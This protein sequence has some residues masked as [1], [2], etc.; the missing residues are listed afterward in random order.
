MHS[1][2]RGPPS[3]LLRL[4]QIYSVHRYETNKSS[5]RVVVKEI[6]ALNKSLIRTRNSCRVY[7]NTPSIIHTTKCELLEDTHLQER[8]YIK[9][10]SSFTVHRKNTWGKG[11]KW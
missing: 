9:I 11:K 1:Y 3:D 10:C 4:R 8:L 2:R 5:I 7:A 6:H